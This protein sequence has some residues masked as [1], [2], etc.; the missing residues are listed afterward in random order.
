ME[1][2]IVVNPVSGNHSGRITG[3]KAEEYLLQC[4][5]T[6]HMHYSTLDTGITSICDTL[7]KNLEEEITIVVVGG[8][9]TMNEALNGLHH[10][11]L[12]KVGFVPAGTGCDMLK[13]M[14][15]SA[16]F[17]S[18]MQSI[19]NNRVL[20]TSAIGCV[21]YGESGIQ[22]RFQVS[23]GIGFDAEICHA[24]AVSTSKKWLHKIHL[25]YLVYL[26]EAVKILKE[27]KNFH[28]KI[29]LETEDI[30]YD[31]CK[32]ISI[33]NHAC[34]GGGYK[35]C[36]SADYQDS[37]LYLCTTYHITWTAFLKLFLKA[38]KGRHV[39]YTQYTK[40]FVSSCMDIES[41]TPQ[42]VHTDGE[43]PYTSRHIHVEVL[44]DKLRLI[45]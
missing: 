23:A 18:I 4:G 24:V 27:K 20:H 28:V 34:E 12:I 45:I 33:H 31:D 21:T 7:T 14:G 40:Q 3:E 38:K 2:H 8:D 29:H 32:F 17:S 5:H 37:T 16:N 22:R 35:F 25:G 26:V 43:T 1:Y 10:L 41:D 6:V 9:G 15:I 42:W 39:A 19:S 11:D 30:E 13:D 36:P 44:P